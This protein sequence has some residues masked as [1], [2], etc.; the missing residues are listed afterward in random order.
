MSSKN[1][2][3]IED[4]PPL[5]KSLEELLSTEYPVRSAKAPSRAMELIKEQVPDLI[6]CDVMLPEQD[7]FQFIKV[8]KT[9]QE[10][11][12]IPVIFLTAL[13][14]DYNQLSGFESGGL[15]YITKP[16]KNADLLSRVRAILSHT[17]HLREQF[18]R[19]SKS[20]GGV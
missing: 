15:D 4:H 8:L 3:V 5:R 18:E 7:G 17:Q 6:I 14:D 9:N 10:Y 2:L 20:R 16:F 19:Q 1:I 11:E 13:S 12:S